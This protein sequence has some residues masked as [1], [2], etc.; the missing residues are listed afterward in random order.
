MRVPHLC[1]RGV[2]DRN[3]FHLLKDRQSL[4]MLAEQVQGLPHLLD[5]VYVDW[6]EAKRC[7]EDGE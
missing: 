6:V 1:S 7:L 3:A 5:V 4:A 2:P